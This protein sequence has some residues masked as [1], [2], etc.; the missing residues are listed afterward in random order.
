MTICPAPETIACGASVQGSTVGG[1][2]NIP[3]TGCNGVAN[4]GPEKSYVFKTNATKKVTVKLDGDNGPYPDLDLA[5]VGQTGMDCD[6]KKKC[7]S[8]GWGATNDEEEEFT[9]SAGVS[10]YII[11]DT[12]LNAGHTFALSVTCQ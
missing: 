4:G 1:P 7:I 5:I 8:W 6:P 2:Q 10:Y 3:S 12:K 11:V 9:A